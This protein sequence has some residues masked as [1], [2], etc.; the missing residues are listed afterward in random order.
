MSSA[1]PHYSGATFT[2]T[3]YERPSPTDPSPWER[4]LGTGT[5]TLERTPYCDNGMLFTLLLLTPKETALTDQWIR[6]SCELDEDYPL[7]MLWDHTVENLGIETA[8]DLFERAAA[9]IVEAWENDEDARSEEVKE[10]L[11]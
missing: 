11:E 2:T 4:E 10:G 1:M 8:T 6:L 3:I 9:E 7:E 5:I